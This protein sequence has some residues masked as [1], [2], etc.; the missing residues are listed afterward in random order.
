[1][2]YRRNVGNIADLVATGIECA[3]GGLSTGARTL[4]LHIQ[5]LEPVFLGGL[6]GALGSYLRSKRRALREPRKPEPPEV[7]QLRVLPCL[8]VM[9][10]MVLLNDA[11]TCA[12]PS[13]TV[14]VIFYGWF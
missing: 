2:R 14:L 8:S 10:I 3:H 1:M 12:I 4:D 11:W 7:A 9:V 6:T 13:T 5:V